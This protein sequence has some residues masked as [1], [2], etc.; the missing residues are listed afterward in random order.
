MEEF[1]DDVNGSSPEES[2]TVPYERFKEVNDK[3]K[4]LTEE[5]STIKN[6]AETQPGGLTPKQKEEI[7]AKEY[8]KGLVKDTLSEFEKTK[9]SEEEQEI[10][11]FQKE[12]NNVLELNSSVDRK[13][14]EK[15][16]ENEADEYGVET[17]SGAM[18]IYK[19]LNET[20]LKAKESAK[21]ELSK[22]PKMPSSDGSGVGEVHND[23]GKSLYQI[24]EEAKKSL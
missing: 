2:Q 6:Q 19:K 18:K 3:V 24:A 4:S 13:E 23:T 22:K 16:L 1:N 5:I 7:E 15:F 9:A 10:A 12:L 21:N 14:F 8:L 17:V 20:T 11:N